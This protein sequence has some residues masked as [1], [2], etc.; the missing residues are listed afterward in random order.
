M[1]SLI[2]FGCLFAN[3]YLAQNNYRIISY[4]RLIKQSSKYRA[5]LFQRKKYFLTSYKTFKRCFCNCQKIDI[6]LRQTLN[7]ILLYRNITLI[8]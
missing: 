4:N 1:L 8:I 3:I 6:Y 2:Y 7:K 5:L